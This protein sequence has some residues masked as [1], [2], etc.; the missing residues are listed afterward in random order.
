MIFTPDFIDSAIPLAEYPRPQMKR[1]SYLPLNGLWDYAFLSSFQADFPEKADGKIIVPYSPE[2]NL[3]GVNRQLRKNE[4]LLYR[5]FFDLP[6]NFNRGRILLNVGACDQICKIYINN[7]EVL[8][9]KGG[10]LPF[11]ADITDF[12]FLEEDVENEIVFVVQDDADSDVYGRGKQKYDRGGIWYT[13]TSG[14]WQSVWLESVPCDYVK[15][16]KILPDY[17]NKLLCL[18]CDVNVTDAISHK[19]FKI[20]VLDGNKKILEQTFNDSSMV[21]DVSSCKEWN[22]ENPELYTIQI[23]FGQDYIESYFGLRKFSIVKSG[24]FKYFALNNKPVFHNGLLDQGYWQEGLYTPPDN[25]AMFNE[26]K[27]VKDL[28]F[29]MLRKH[30]K[31]EPLLWYHY[32]DVLGVLVWQDMV[33][34]GAEYPLHRIFLCP[35]FNL[36]LIDTNHKKMGRSEESCK[37]YYKETSETIENLYNSVSVCLWTLFNEAWGQF[38]SVNVTESV[39]KQDSSRL[40][41][42]ASGWQDTGSGDVCS[43]HVYFRKVKIKN[44]KKRV[45]ALTEFGGYSYAMP[46]HTF[47]TR[48]FGYKMLKTQD[49]LQ[50]A[51]ENLYLTEIIP[52]IQTQGLSASVYTELTDIED[53]INGLFTY[54]REIKIDKERLKEVNKKVYDTFKVITDESD[55]R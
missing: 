12:L 16:I 15:S 51:I 18:K 54:D 20:K 8:E 48:H 52:L 11:V 29:N 40:I 37:Q 26:I 39:R 14:I 27:A 53:E 32:C 33:N 28:G 6:R 9:H 3:S 23:L 55:I 35:F 4:F 47:S 13:A 31:T 46:E 44:D 24:K 38:D 21:L 36:R 45:L 22:L 19:I 25:K 34:G 5:R 41:D 1:D 17:D 10:Y 50:K 30:I 42:S 2:S 7:K 49:E 43:R